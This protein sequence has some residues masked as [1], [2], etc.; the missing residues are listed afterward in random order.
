MEELLDELDIHDAPC[1]PPRFEPRRLAERV[2]ANCAAV[3][4]W[5]VRAL[6]T[7]MCV[8]AAMFT[9]LLCA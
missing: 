3:F 2:I 7:R 1:V 9:C 8:H 6:H 5:V 4:V